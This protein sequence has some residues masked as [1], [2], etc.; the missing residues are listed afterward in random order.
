MKEQKGTKGTIII[1]DVG[2]CNCGI[3]QILS[4]V[5]I[6]GQEESMGHNHQSEL[7][8]LCKSVVVFSCMYVQIAQNHGAAV[9]P[10]C[11]V[12]KQCI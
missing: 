12:R 9:A 3:R 11:K 7:G 6:L 8:P 2:G 4:L 10:A 1:K 5:P